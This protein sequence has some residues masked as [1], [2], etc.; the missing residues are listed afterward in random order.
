M[1]YFSLCW[2]MPLL[3]IA[4]QSDF[5]ATQDTIL[6]CHYSCD[7]YDVKE[8]LAILAKVTGKLNTFNRPGSNQVHSDIVGQVNEHISSVIDRHT[9]EISRNINSILHT[10]ARQDEQLQTISNRLNILE[11]S[12]RNTSDINSLLEERIA[13]EL[14]NISVFVDS[15]S[16]IESQLDTC[17]NATSSKEPRGATIETLLSTIEH[18]AT[19][20]FYKLNN[21]KEHLYIFDMSLRMRIL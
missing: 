2:L 15:M 18:F 8:A 11:Q 17:V 4:E 9:N 10:V 3:F 19:K 7:D 21:L 12:S 6:Y 14:R 1:T 16:R 13:T 20:A 5:A